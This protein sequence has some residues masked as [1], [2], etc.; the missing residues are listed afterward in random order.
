[1]TPREMRVEALGSI[2]R[3]GKG[4]A[5]RI[6]SGPLPTMISAAVLEAARRWT[7]Q[8]AQLSGQPAT[9][10]TRIVF[11]FRPPGNPR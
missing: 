10:E 7:F 4:T 1:M 3:S 5:A 11:E 9:S 2:D 8:P 6:V